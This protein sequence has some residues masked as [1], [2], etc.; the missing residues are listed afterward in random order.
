MGLWRGDVL[1]FAVWCESWLRVC[2][3]VRWSLG[4]CGV[5]CVVVECCVVW[6]VLFVWSVCGGGGGV[7][8]VRWVVLGA[9]G[10][11][12]GLYGCV[13]CVLS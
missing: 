7:C 10:G 4:G 8:A 11:W 6:W 9:G 3:C 5:W 13:S 1:V 12:L 2:W